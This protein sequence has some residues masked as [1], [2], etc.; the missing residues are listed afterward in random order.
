[1]PI[2][3]AAIRTTGDQ[4]TV[5]TGQARDVRANLTAKKTDGVFNA[6]MT[7]LLASGQTWSFHDAYDRVWRDWSADWLLFPVAP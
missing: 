1:L 6:D 3:I 4:H 5:N 2:C 7:A